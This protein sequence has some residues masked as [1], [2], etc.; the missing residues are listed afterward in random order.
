MEGSALMHL[1]LVVFVNRFA[2]LTAIDPPLFILADALKTLDLTS[3]SSWSYSTTRSWSVTGPVKKS[4]RPS[5]SIA[6]EYVSSASPIR[7]RISFFFEINEI[8]LAKGNIR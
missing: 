8:V 5:F 6:W 3:Y 2:L 7:E 1:R 4:F